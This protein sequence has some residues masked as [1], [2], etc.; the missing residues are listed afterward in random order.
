MRASEPVI[1]ILRP[2]EEAALEAFLLPR[3]ASSM[4]LIGN[5]RESGLNDTGDTYSGTYAAA[6]DDHRITSVAAH[7]WNG[8][9]VLQAPAHLQEVWQAAVKASQRPIA[10]LTGLKDQVSA[11]K[12]ALDIPASAIQL[13]EPEKL[14][15]LRLADLRV[16]TI[17]STGGAHGRRIE[18]QDVD[19]L[20]QWRVAYSIETQGEKDRPELW[21]RSRASIERALQEGHGWVL[22]HSGEPVAYN[23]FNAAIREAV[24][25]GGV[26]TPPQLRRRGYGRAVVAAS[27]LDARNECVEKAILFTG[28]RN[29]AAQKAYTALGFRYIGDYHMLLLEPPLPASLAV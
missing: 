27:L 2:G 22:E 3:I 14:Y 9:L 19:L 16:P 29:M 11:V 20:T 23:A 5:M 17:L 13:D 6:F 12:R 28:L 24:Q 4:F 7:Y 21:Q 18:P 25:V 1:R 15:S 8:I 26:Y 10:G